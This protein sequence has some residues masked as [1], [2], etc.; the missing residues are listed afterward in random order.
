MNPRAFICG[1]AGETLDARERDFFQ[2]KQPWGAI[3]FARN[4]GTPEQIRALCVDIRLA[5][6][7]NNAPILIDQE[8][9]RVQRLKPPHWP[10]YPSAGSLASIYR[11]NQSAG[12]QA[13]R[14][15][16]GLIADDLVAV[17]LNVDCLPVLD[18]PVQGASEIVGDR[19]YGARVEDIIALGEEAARAMLLG[20]VLPVMKHIPGHGRANVDSHKALPQVDMAHDLLT[21]TDFAPFAALKSLPMAMTAHVVYSAIDPEAPAT[22]SPAVIGDVIRSQIGFDG[23][24]MSDDLS[25]GALQGSLSQRAKASIA[26]GC[27]IALHCNGELDEMLEVADAVAPLAGDAWRRAEAALSQLQTPAPFDR[28][29]ATEQLQKLVGESAK[30]S[31]GG[32][33]ST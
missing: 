18:V 30:F 3:L 22:L 13:V 19:A 33:S 4:C 2:Q 17:G 5:L 25:M 20:G 1:C 8:G 14:L 15:T 12:L 31:I 29:H 32:P 26:A 16:C 11:A 10:A 9:G 27:D 28:D 24:L 21:K 23:L 7:R 6:G